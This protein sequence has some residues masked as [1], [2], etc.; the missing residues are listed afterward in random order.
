MIVYPVR[1][2]TFDVHGTLIHAP[3]LGEIYSEILCRHGLEIAPD[4]AHQTVR[5]VWEEFA[6]S[7]RPGVDLFASHPGGSKGFWSQFVDRVCRHLGCASPSPFAKAELFQKFSTA[8]AWEI[9]PEVPAVLERILDKGIRCGVISNWDD[10]LPILLRNLRLDRFFD[11][12]VYSQRVA[13]DKPYPEIFGQALAELSLPPAQVVHV[14]DRVREDVEGARGIGMQ[15]IHIARDGS[16]GDLIDLEPL[17]DMLPVQ[18]E[19]EES[20]S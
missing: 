8:D 15:S 2:V 11:T 16:D 5:R 10:R 7:R 6:C 14:G 9:Y 13:V 20:G 1:A 4:V 12:V 3:R 18:P 17:V 19:A